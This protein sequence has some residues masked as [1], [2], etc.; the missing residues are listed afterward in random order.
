MDTRRA[1]GADKEN[2]VF[3][4][5]DVFLNIAAIFHLLFGLACPLQLN[6][7]PLPHGWS[8]SKMV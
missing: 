4:P 6:H 3:R 7:P 5:T 1:R 8:S 2:S